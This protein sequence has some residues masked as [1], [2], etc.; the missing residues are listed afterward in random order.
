MTINTAYA[1][2]STYNRP[3]CGA[4][5]NH[6][7]GDTKVVSHCELGSVP[8]GETINDDLN[9]A[10]IEAI[11][12][13]KAQIS[14]KSVNPTRPPASLHICACSSL[15]RE[16]P[17]TLHDGGHKRQEGGHIGRCERTVGV[18]GRGVDTTIRHGCGSSLVARPVGKAMLQMLTGRTEISSMRGQS[19]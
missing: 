1:R 19:L 17:R 13:H 9:T 8:Q 6:R 11:E 2:L 5:P 3:S 4:S 10:L 18:G 16:T 15:K 14:N 7:R 12:C